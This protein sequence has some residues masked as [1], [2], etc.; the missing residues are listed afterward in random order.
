ML[1]V[2]KRARTVVTDVGQIVCLVGQTTVVATGDTLRWRR[3]QGR[4]QFLHG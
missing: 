4:Q 1:L 2:T 3:C